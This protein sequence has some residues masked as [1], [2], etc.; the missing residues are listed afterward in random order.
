MN[1]EMFNENIAPVINLVFSGINAFAIVFLF[2]QIRL[3]VK[4]NKLQSKY[5]FIDTSES[6]AL[7]KAM[8]VALAKLGIPLFNRSARTLSDEEIKR[9]FG[10]ASATVCVNHFI[11][12]LQ[13]LCAALKHG[14]IDGAV[15][16]AVHAGRV[17]WW[18]ELLQNYVD[19]QR[20]GLNDSTI[21]KNFTDIGSASD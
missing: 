13:N 14:I 6:A 1:I 5:N 12:D 18:H 11:N 2:W 20:K 10:D 21:W 9:I 7:E 4:W 8:H 15:F 19:S 17:R 3:T 16:Q